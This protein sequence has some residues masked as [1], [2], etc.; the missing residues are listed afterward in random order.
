M[1]R[2]YCGGVMD[3]YHAD[4]VSSKVRSKSGNWL[5]SP[6]ILILAVETNRHMSWF[7]CGG[8][9]DGY[10]ADVVS[11]KVSSKSGNWLACCSS[12]WGWKN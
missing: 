4:V 5:I 9:M 1:S 11:S 8:V 2:F 7:Y 6:V 3:G 10:H 12:G